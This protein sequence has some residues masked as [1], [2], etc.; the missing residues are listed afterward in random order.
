MKYNDI[1]V[2]LLAKQLLEGLLL[3]FIVLR[4]RLHARRQAERV[5]LALLLLAYVQVLGLLL[6]R[7]VLLLVLATSAV[8]LGMLVIL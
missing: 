5:C 6:L 2:S 7:L 4:F 3:S 8:L 1:L